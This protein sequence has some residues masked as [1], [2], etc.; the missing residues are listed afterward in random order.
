MH[1]FGKGIHTHK[2]VVRF[3]DWDADDDLDMLVGTY[4]PKDSFR[5]L[6]YERLPD[7]TFQVHELVKLPDASQRRKL[8]LYAW[9]PFNESDRAV[10]VEGFQVA[11]FDGDDKLDILLCTE[12]PVMSYKNERPSNMT[13]LNRAL[14]PSDSLENGSVILSVIGH[15]SCDMQLVDFD[16]DGDLDLFTSGMSRYFERLPAELV[17]SKNPLDPYNRKVLQAVDFD[18]D[19]HLELL[20]DPDLGDDHDPP[21]MLHIVSLKRTF[22]GSFAKSSQNPFVDI[23]VQRHEGVLVV[24]DWNSDGLPDIL[25]MS[26]RQRWLPGSHLRRR[27][28]TWL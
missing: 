8:Q 10:T 2:D 26:G 24:A 16:G 1:T 18:G 13:L 5:I 21:R 23:K 15:E 7:D 20:A 22:D 27:L 4:Y 14:L 25:V 3:A 28:E 12:G 6:F 19:G 11:D 17:E 9:Q